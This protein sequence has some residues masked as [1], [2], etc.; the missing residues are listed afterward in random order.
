MCSP[1]DGKIPKKSRAST[2][3]DKYQDALHAQ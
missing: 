2:H 3:R 1:S